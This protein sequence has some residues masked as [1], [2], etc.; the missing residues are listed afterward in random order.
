MEYQW[1]V[2]TVYADDSQGVEWMNEDDARDFLTYYAESD[3]EP[4]M[5]VRSRELVCRPIEPGEMKVAE[6][7]YAELRQA[8]DE[9][10]AARLAKPRCGCC[11]R[12]VAPLDGD[13]R[14]GHCGVSR[15][16]GTHDDDQPCQ[17]R[18]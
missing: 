12:R 18:V 3:A 16:P 9:R 14:C 11:G 10:V 4:A 7:H 1:G 6:S 8:A 2:R 17:G 15:T 13:G 5:R